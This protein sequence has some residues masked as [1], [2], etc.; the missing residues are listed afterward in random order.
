MPSPFAVEVSQLYF[1]Y[2]TPKKVPVY[3]P[4]PFKRIVFEKKYALHDV[5]FRMRAGRITALL[6]KNGSGKTTLIKLITGAR[7]SQQGNI[8]IFGES[9]EKM[10]SKIGLCLG[11]TLVYHRLSG[12][13]NLEY[14]GKLYNVSNLNAR[15]NELCG[16]LGLTPHLDQLVESYSYGMKTKLALARSM[17]H[18]PEILILDEPTLG[19]DIQIAM[20]IREFIK[21]LSCTV[22]LTTHY[23][24]E[25]ET[26]A[27][28]LCIIDA[29]KILSQGEKKN[30]IQSYGATSAADAFI[31]ALDGE[32]I[33]E[34]QAEMR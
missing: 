26:L 30:V 10:K 11:G 19:I 34:F 9:P 2:L 22:L 6:G 32:E 5:N 31:R 29:G 15:I 16:M 1:Y 8:K 3:P 14:F 21:N 17:I 4:L 20:Q 33:R 7:L 12:R 13:E 25:A 18:S 23:M 28:D 27:D 24:E